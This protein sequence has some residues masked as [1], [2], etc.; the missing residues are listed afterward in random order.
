MS[1]SQIHFTKISGRVQPGELDHYLQAMDMK[2]K[3]ADY[4]GPRVKEA[5]IT[6]SM[7][8][9]GNAEPEPFVP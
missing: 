2:A 6:C 5:V 9:R 4:F 8:H 1:S 7:C 3:K